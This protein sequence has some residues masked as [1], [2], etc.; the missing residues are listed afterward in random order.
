MGKGQIAELIENDKIDTGEGIGG[1]ALATE[2][3]LSFK[4]VDQTIY[5][6]LNK[7]MIAHSNRPNTML[8][9]SNGFYIFF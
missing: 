3:D 7:T 5:M 1:T 8:C 4:S 6:A 9:F 2:L